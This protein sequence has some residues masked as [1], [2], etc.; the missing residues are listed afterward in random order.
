MKENVCS[1]CGHSLENNLHGP[2]QNDFYYD[3]EKDEYVACGSCTYCRECNP[4]LKAAE[5]ANERS[6]V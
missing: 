6:E 4:K 5:T 2:D 1:N 3:A